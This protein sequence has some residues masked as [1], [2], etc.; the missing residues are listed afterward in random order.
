MAD[1]AGPRPWTVTLAGLMTLL[2]GAANVLLAIVASAVSGLA[3]APL[4]ATGLV[5]AGA[6][7]GWL[8]W[9][10]LR[11]SNWALPA[12]TAL[13]ALLLLAR[14]AVDEPAGDPIGVAAGGDASQVLL[15]GMV[16]VL[17]LAMA[18]QRRW[19]RRSAVD[20]RG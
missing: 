3:M 10:I 4:A 6:L 20:D 7:T 16:V 14:V 17:A 5:A 11:G 1:Q 8:G 12:T 15:V 18:R 2:V 13:F 9:R 19:A